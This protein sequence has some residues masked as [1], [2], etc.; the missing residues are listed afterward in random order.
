MN[1]QESPNVAV[2]GRLRPVPRV[3][4]WDW[5]LHAACRGMDVAVFYHPTGERDRARRKRIDDAKAICRACPVLG[6]CRAQALALR[7][8]F[9]IWGGLSELERSHILTPPPGSSKQ[10]SP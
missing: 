9:G 8:P 7:E 5:Q 10:T 4:N 3:E 1:K 2:D 6:E